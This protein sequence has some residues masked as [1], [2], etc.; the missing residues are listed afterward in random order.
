MP[1]QI[2]SSVG[3][4]AQALG[5]KS[6][7][8]SVPYHGG[9]SYQACA[10]SPAWPGWRQRCK[11]KVLWAKPQH[12]QENPLEPQW[13]AEPQRQLADEGTAHPPAQSQDTAMSRFLV[14]PR[15]CAPFRPHVIVEKSV[16]VFI[17]SGGWLR[18]GRG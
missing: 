16:V 2:A 4:C 18:K 11:E 17:W 6:C 13:W 14:A 3:R 8:D 15:R 1:E 7:T 10:C 9:D 5:I 12:R